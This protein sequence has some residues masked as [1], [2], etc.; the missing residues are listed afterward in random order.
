MSGDADAEAAILRKLSTLYFRATTIVIVAI[1]GV[2]AIYAIVLLKGVQPATFFRLALSWSPCLFYLWALLALRRFFGELSNNPTGARTG[3]AQTLSVVGLAL[4]LG[5]LTS[6]LLTPLI[7][8]LTLP[9][10]LGGFPL[11][12]VPALTL[13]SVGAGLLIVTRMLKRALRFEAE[14]KSLKTVLEGFV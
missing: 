13:G 4:L 8:M 1:L 6:I 12:D 7:S 2:M 10:R 5:A 11:F 14:A 3:I 9:H